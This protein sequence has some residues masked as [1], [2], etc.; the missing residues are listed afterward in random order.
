MKKRSTKAAKKDRQARNAASYRREVQRCANHLFAAMRL[1]NKYGDFLNSNPASEAQRDAAYENV[2]GSWALA[3]LDLWILCRGS[4]GNLA[5]T[6]H[7]VALA[8]EGKLRGAKFDALIEGGLNHAY[9][10][11]V[12]RKGPDHFGSYPTPQQLYDSI[13]LVAT[14]KRL[15]KLPHKRAAM[16]RAKQLY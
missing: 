2:H 9:C 13:S 12:L 6:L 11:H 3:G 16:R 7:A 15:S 8:A 10:K 14:K 1:Q 5:K 4:L